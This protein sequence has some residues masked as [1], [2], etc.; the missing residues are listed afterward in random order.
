M[1]ILLTKTYWML[2]VLC[3]TLSTMRPKTPKV[4]Q[5]SPQLGQRHMNKQKQVKGK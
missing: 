4:T 5:P 3:I 1:S 2:S